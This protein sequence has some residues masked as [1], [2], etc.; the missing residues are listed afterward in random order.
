MSV[1]IAVVGWMPKI[2][3]NSG[4]ISD[5]PPMPV[6]PTSTPM[7]SP[8]KMI[9]GSNWVLPLIDFPDLLGQKRGC[10]RIPAVPLTEVRQLSLRVERHAYGELEVLASLE[11]D[12]DAHRVLG[13]VGPSGC[14]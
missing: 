10:G 13:L 3:I 11:L 4:V 8:K 14:G 12:L 5:P 9:A 1:P 6:M 2:R 7:P